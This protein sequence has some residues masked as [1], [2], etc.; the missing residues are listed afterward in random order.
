LL[1]L[2][3]NPVWAQDFQVR[4]TSFEQVSEY[5]F[6]FNIQIRNN[7]LDPAGAGAWAYDAS[8]FQIDINTAMLNGGQFQGVYLTVDNSGTDLPVTQLL[9]NGDFFYSSVNT[10]LATNSPSTATDDEVMLMN[11]DEWRTITRFIVKLRN[12]AGDGFLNLGDVD[13]EFTFRS[14]VDTK[15]F[16]VVY[17]MDG[18][19]AR[20]GTGPGIPGSTTELLVQPEDMIIDIPARQ[21]AGYWFTGE[22]DW[23]DATKWN[24]TL[25]AATPAY[26]QAVPD[27]NANVII[28][29]NSTIQGGNDISLLPDVNGN[30]GELTVLTGEEPLFT[31]TVAEAGA[32]PGEITFRVRVSPL[33]D[34]VLG[35]ATTYVA[36]G[37]SVQVPAGIEYRV[38][39]RDNTG[40]DLAFSGWSSPSPGVVLTN[41]LGSY[42]E[43]N[44]RFVMPANNAIINSTWVE[45]KK[46]ATIDAFNQEL[47]TDINNPA[48]FKEATE[49]EVDNVKYGSRDELFSSL[50]LAPLARLT[51]DKLFNDHEQGAAAITVKSSPSGTGSLIHNSNDVPATIERYISGPGHHLVSIPFIQATNP[52]SGW[53]IWSYLFEY[54]PAAGWQALGAP[55]TT[56][57]NVD[58]GYMVYK[59][60]GPEKWSADTTY[61]MAGPMNNDLFV[62]NVSGITGNHNLVPNP[63]PSAIDWDAGGWTK[64]NLFDAIWIWNHPTGNYAAYGS[65]AGTNGATK[66]IPVGQAFFVQSSAATPALSMTNDVRVHSAQAF[67]KEGMEVENL[68]RIKAMANNYSDEIIVRFMEGS[69]N[70]FD[71]EFDAVKMFGLED[72]PQ[73]YS[74]ADDDVKL[75]INSLP[76]QE[77]AIEIPFGFQTEFSGDVVL[78]FT[79]V[80]S[81]DPEVSLYLH[82]NLTGVITNLKTTPQY[83]FTHSE[84]ND[85]LRFKLSFNDATSV[86]EP[87]MLNIQAYFS[88][89]MLNLFIT[90]EISGTSQVN[91]YNAG[92]QVVYS[93]NVKPGKSSV[94]VPVLPQGVYMIQV[95]NEKQTVVRKALYN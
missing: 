74:M 7:R 29:G 13:P 91:I 17:Y 30:G 94:T 69:S 8:Q 95:V 51:V 9:G 10:A 93:G 45:A 22:G 35:S 68:L 66:D 23:T 53:F 86:Y 60:P 2:M 61:S 43:Y 1:G 71:G 63:Y 37:S 21:L 32:Y 34:W 15:V 19:I 62:A 89:Q 26:V 75:S 77:E 73:L 84:E 85:P 24:Q 25:K 42:P 65:G 82:D 14:F 67:F 20:R 55:T 64:T 49:F 28:N 11:H 16:S 6:Q 48:Y 83:A 72:A 80:D 57:L 46:S 70:N 39:T 90:D 50:T 44:N 88:G 92:G 38:Y 56:P 27:P 12:A 41:P 5:E 18:S 87:D 59:Y 79:S 31:L 52:V 4:M 81:F 54:D 78:E 33:G 47:L 36:S 58:Q 76:F 40:G 3:L